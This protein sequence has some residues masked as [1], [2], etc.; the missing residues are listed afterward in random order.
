MGH[1]RFIRSLLLKRK[2]WAKWPPERVE[3]AR[4]APGPPLVRSHSSRPLASRFMARRGHA[5][6]RFKP[7]MLALPLRR[8]R[9][10]HADHSPSTNRWARRRVAG[11][12]A[13]EERCGARSAVVGARAPRGLQI[14]QLGPNLLCCVESRKWP[15]AN[16]RPHAGGCCSARVNPWIA[17]SPR[18]PSARGSRD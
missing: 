8:A 14:S 17:V 1:V 3:A 12:A 18:G 13:S 6:F 10:T 7:W 15:W 9:G 4:R 11:R 5:T 16:P 2:N